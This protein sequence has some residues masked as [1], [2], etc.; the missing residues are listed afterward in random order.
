VNHLYLACCL[1]HLGH[2]KDSEE[3][4]SK[5]PATR[6]Q[7]RILFH[8]AH[9]MNDETKLMKYHAKITDSIEDQLSLASIHYLRS[10]FQEATDI[11]KRLLIES[12]DYLALQVP[13][14][15]LIC[16]ATQFMS[17]QCYE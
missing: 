2:W 6:L 4:A 3:S 17:C 8:L 13:A 7:N 14:R 11:Y 1:F 9:R 12:R 15:S 16:S 10:H 5:G